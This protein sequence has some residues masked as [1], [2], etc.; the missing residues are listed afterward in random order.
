[1]NLTA[2]VAGHPVLAGV[3]VL[4]EAHCLWKIAS[5]AEQR[6]TASSLSDLDSIFQK[7]LQAKVSWF[8]WRYVEITEN[9]GSKVRLSHYSLTEKTCLIFTNLFE[10][11][12]KVGHQR[13]IGRRISTKITDL[14]AQ[15]DLECRSGFF[16]SV[17]STIRDFFTETLFGLSS[18]RKSWIGYVSGKPL[19]H[20]GTSLIGLSRIF[21]Y[22][23]HADYIESFKVCPVNHGGPFCC[24]V[25]NIRR[26]SDYPDLRSSAK[27]WSPPQDPQKRTQEICKRKAESR[28]TDPEF[29]PF[30]RNPLIKCK[31]CKDNDTDLILSQ[32]I[33]P[34]ND[35]YTPFKYF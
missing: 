21:E 33:E 22:Y 29:S 30:S 32:T 1:M 20:I 3:A 24:P 8:G 10:L 25:R 7:P 14:Y 23:N 17:F 27:L 4:A 31:E 18:P 34:E 15:S 28:S 26:T 6:I 12:F 11:G 13:D 5:V 16:K 9:D 2:I 35:E 19:R